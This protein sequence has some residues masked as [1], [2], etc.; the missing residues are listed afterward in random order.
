MGISLVELTQIYAPRVTSKVKAILADP[1][2]P[3][4]H[5]YVSL[6]SAHGNRAI[7]CNTKQ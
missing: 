1:N 5:H 2:H 6:P 3:L 7:K 4:H